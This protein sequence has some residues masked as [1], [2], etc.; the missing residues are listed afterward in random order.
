MLGDPVCKLLS[1]PADSVL[2]LYVSGQAAAAGS[3]V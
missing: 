3:S 1:G 2:H